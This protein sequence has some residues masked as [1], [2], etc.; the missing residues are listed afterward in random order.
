M[1]FLRQIIVQ[2]A[3]TK[4]DRGADFIST[5]QE[6]AQ[7]SCLHEKGDSAEGIYPSGMLPW[8][9][10]EYAADCHNYVERYLILPERGTK[11]VDVAR[12]AP[13]VRFFCK[14][15]RL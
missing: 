3:V 9:A 4:H 15:E 6:N 14:G 12:L 1:P 5:V 11:T 2:T 7:D 8:A 13:H 10:S